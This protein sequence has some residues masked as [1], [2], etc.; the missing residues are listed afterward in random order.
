MIEPEIIV[1]STGDNEYALEAL[2]P[3]TSNVAFVKFKCDPKQ[4]SLYG[5][6]EIAKKARLSGEDE[7]KGDY[8]AS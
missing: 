4:I 2:W 5:L 3:D 7:M 6:F 1:R 8:G